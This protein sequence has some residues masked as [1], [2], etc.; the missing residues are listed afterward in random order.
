MKGSIR[1]SQFNRVLFLP[2]LL[3][4]LVS[5]CKKDNDDMSGAPIA[6]FQY[7]IS[8]TNFLEV[9]FS[10]F[11]QNA[12]SYMWDFGDG[13][14]STEANPV[15]VFA[16]DGTYEVKLTAVNADGDQSTKSE[17]ISLMDPDAIL[18]LLAGSSSKTWYLQR[19][20]IA[21][22]IGPEI[23]N[24]AWWSFGGVAPLGDRP[25]IL[26]DEYTF[27]RDGR[28]EFN[29]NGTLFIDSEGNGG[30][31]P[32]IPEGCHDETEAGVFSAPGGVDVSAFG[33]GGDYTY[34]FDNAAGTMTLN[35][36]G[37][38]IG[39]A[40]KT[41]AGDNYTPISVKEYKVFNFAD[42][43]VA[44]S[45]Q[46]AIVGDGFV[47]NFYLVSYD[48]IADLPEIPSAKP[49]ADFSFVKDGSTIT[50][51]NLSKNATSYMWDFG[52][53]A[54]STAISPMH[55]YGADGEYTLTLTV[56]DGMGQTDMKS[57]QVII[58]SATYSP[59][60]LSSA[61]GK[62]WKLAGAGSYIVGP[63]PGSAEWY[64]GPTT[65]DVMTQA[66]RFNDEF[67]FFDNGTFQYDSKGDLWFD[68]FLGGPN[69]ICIDESG[70]PA[71]YSGLA[72]GTHMFEAADGVGMDRPTV[73]VIGSGA[74]VGFAKAFNGGE[75]NGSNAPAS[76]ITYEVLEYTS[77]AQADFLTLTIDISGGQV[78]GAYWTIKLT[79][80]K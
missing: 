68:D 67:I 75:L 20:G 79:S 64:T 4:V 17:S 38:Y 10:N 34:E 43:P 5:G 25:C 9:T 16:A 74:F 26:D 19:E 33:N 18:T 22:G 12:T 47:W 60:V 69:N 23:N 77:T 59:A 73:K 61:S 45:L 37:A 62:V 58:S 57:A 15:H 24:N 1:L 63:G 65:D 8:T 40:N 6:S 72:S 42:G 76:D 27:H 7:T 71:I 48:N 50:I 70:L 53:G 55:T 14:T 2:L 36:L 28:F 49:K 78:G 13:N 52:D 39:L 66:C 46:I 3:L 56:M 51:S 29:S 30:W 41:A 31:L 35:G 54:T 32:G 44:D 11:S 21:L 80:V